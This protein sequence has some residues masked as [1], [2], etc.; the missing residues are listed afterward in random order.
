MNSSL[1]SGNKK[2]MLPSYN[3]P[4]TSIYFKVIF[5]YKIL[6]HNASLR[7]LKNICIPKHYIM[8]I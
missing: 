4:F 2:Q 1:K 5:G 3:K 8:F 7:T 6:K